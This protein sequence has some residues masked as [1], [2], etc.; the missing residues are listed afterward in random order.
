MDYTDFGDSYMYINKIQ[1]NWK[2][3]AEDHIIGPVWCYY[4]LFCFPEPVDIEV[5]GKRIHTRPNACIFNEPKHPRGFYFHRNTVIHWLHADKEIAQLL[6]TYQ[7][8]LNDVFYPEDP[9]LVEELFGKLR[10]EFLANRS[11]REQMLCAYTQALVIA[12]SRREN[13]AQTDPKRSNGMLSR[14]RELRG[15]ILSEPKKTWSVAQMAES[16]GMS[17]SRLHAVYK[18]AFGTSPMK[19]V[20]RSKIDCAQSM[21]LLDED[22]P[23][24]TVAEKLGYTNPYHFIRQFKELT[25]VTPGTY[26]KKNL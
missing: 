6:G 7:I 3:K 26:R 25:G 11:H 4:N 9:A 24:S 23:V 13:P 8:P 14:L 10:L 12:L 19:D 2:R 15:Q 1:F 20:I 5:A 21:L 22:I 17:P 18:T 16:L